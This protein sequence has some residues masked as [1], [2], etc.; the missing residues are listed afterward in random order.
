MLLNKIKQGFTRRGMRYLNERRGWRTNRKIVVIESDD[1]GSI[2]MPNKIVFERMLKLN[3]DVHR[4]NYSR[5][6]TLASQQD[7]SHLFDVLSSFKDGNGNHP[8]ITA[9][10]IVANPDFE[11]IREN[12]FQ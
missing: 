5:Y 7:F 1:W 11:K 12:D 2:R 6:D 4:C 9:N 3:Y 10:T 8:I